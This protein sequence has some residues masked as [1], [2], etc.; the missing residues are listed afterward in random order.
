MSMPKSNKGRSNIQKSF[1]FNLFGLTS[2]KNYCNFSKLSNSIT[3]GRRLLTVRLATLHSAL[4]TIES[5]WPYPRQKGFTFIELI[6]TVA[7]LIIIAI[8][9]TPAILTQLANMEAKR[10]K[11]ELMTT[12][13]VAKA[14]SY[15][16]RQDLIVCLSNAGGRCHRDSDK[17]LLLFVD[18]N[19]NQNFDSQVDVLLVEQN[20]NPKYSTLSL[21]V[22]SNR[23]YT[24]FWGDSG[25]P[26]GHF[27]HIKYCPTSTYNQSMYQIS[28]NQ[29]GIVKYKPND[30]HP[31][32]CGT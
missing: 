14:E 11:N 30:I 29:L 25:K 2:I 10:I 6:V 5:V 32:E 4:R 20:L 31:T 21:R 22:G 26:R 9:A 3:D 17:K 8:I 7:I 12:M 15:I 27:G 18:N 16:R 19:D 1:L 24:K 13:A 23:H 28:F